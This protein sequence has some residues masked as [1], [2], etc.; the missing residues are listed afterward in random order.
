MTIKPRFENMWTIGNIVTIVGMVIGGIVAFVQVRAD[1]Q[2]LR[3]MVVEMKSDNDSEEIRLRALE[4]GFGRVEE[5][6]VS[7][8]SLLQQLVNQNVGNR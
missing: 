3:E 8:Q 5:R 4:L 1:V 2:Q 7:M 6:L